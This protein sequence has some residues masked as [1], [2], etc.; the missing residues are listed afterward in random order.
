ML[1]VIARSRQYFQ[2]DRNFAVCRDYFKMFFEFVRL[3]IYRNVTSHS[4]P[5]FNDL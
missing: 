2:Y 3:I 4:G 5:R 1:H